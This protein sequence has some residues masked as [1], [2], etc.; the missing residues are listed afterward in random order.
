LVAL[1]PYVH[2]KTFALLAVDAL[3]TTTALP[4]WRAVMR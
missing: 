1:P 4:L 3:C 2:W